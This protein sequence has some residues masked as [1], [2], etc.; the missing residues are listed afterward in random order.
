ML[1][2]RY[3]YL[4]YTHTSVQQLGYRSRPHAIADEI[5]HKTSNKLATPFQ[6]AFLQYASKSNTIMPARQK[7]LQ[8]PRFLKRPTRRHLIGRNWDGRPNEHR[9]K[10]LGCGKMA[11]GSTYCFEGIG[12]LVLEYLMAGG[13][14]E[15]WA[16]QRKHRC[17]CW[18]G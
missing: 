16:P 2:P 3:R 6:M 9:I 18:D 10:Q 8:N 4:W 14:E 1:E 15:V 5:Q 12:K 11:F 13:K 17:V 7:P